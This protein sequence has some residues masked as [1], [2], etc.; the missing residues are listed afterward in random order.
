M[1]KIFLAT[2][3]SGKINELTGP[4]TKLGLGIVTLKDLPPMEEIAETGESFEENALLKATIAAKTTGLPSI[5]DDS[6]LIVDALGGAPG[7]YSARYGEDLEFMPN[8]SR[9]ERNIRKLIAEMANVPARERSC[10]FVSVIACVRPDGRAITA[11]GLWNGQILSERRGNN[12][13]GYDP[14]FYDPILRRTA[15]Q[16]SRE[17]KTAH[18]HRARAIKNILTKLPAFL[19]DNFY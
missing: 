5:A 13:F 8:E 18:S 15:A 9:D 7:I 4:L 12:G 1:S 2:T 16:L 6:G 11:K 3:N 10:R 14:V 19:P 17:E